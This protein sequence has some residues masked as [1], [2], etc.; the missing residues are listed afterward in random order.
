MRTS[1]HQEH[2]PVNLLTT[3]AVEGTSAFVEMQRTLLD[4]IQRENEIVF[5]GMKER[6]GKFT[7]AAALTDLTR[8]TLDAV[9]GAQQEFLTITSKRS[10]EWLHAD[11]TR[12]PKVSATI[13]EAAR[14]GLEAFARAQNKFLAALEEE[15]TRV[16][17]GKQRVSNPAKKTELAELGRDAASAFIEA[18]Q[19]LVDIFGQQMNVNLDLALQSVETV[20]P[21]RLLPVLS[22][23]GKEAGRLLDAE[24]SL[25]KSSIR[26]VTVSKGKRART[27][28]KHE[29]AK[30]A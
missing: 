25:V 2:S 19:R 4:L 5:T 3:F 18:Q 1:T 30:A 22:F 16:T 21:S 10:M 11:Q 26:P 13:L 24:K 27:H 17:A 12:K 23:A 20:S 8:R 29:K 7:P 15:T 14:D 9:L 28:S 6:V